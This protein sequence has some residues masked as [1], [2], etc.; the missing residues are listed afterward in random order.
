MTAIDAPKQKSKRKQK[1][2]QAQSAFLS[3]ATDTE[4]TES[5]VVARERIGKPTNQKQMITAI[6]DIL[7][8][9]NYHSAN[10]RLDKRIR[11]LIRQRVDAQ[12]KLLEQI[13]RNAELRLEIA[14]LGGVPPC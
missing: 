1:P 7:N 10:I 11:K 6:T 13:K 8:A 5:E 14:R 12:Q 2:T 9:D 4:Q 3:V